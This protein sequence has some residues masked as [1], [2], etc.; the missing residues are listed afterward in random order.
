MQT[1]AG[2]AVGSGDTD[3][4]E[5]L[6]DLLDVLVAAAWTPKR[7]NRTTRRSIR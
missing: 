4:L 5:A 1:C 6:A 2:G 7:I 3:A